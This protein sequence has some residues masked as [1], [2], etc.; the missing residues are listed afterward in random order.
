MVRNRYAWLAI[1][2]GVLF[3]LVVAPTEAR[4]RAPYEQY[5]IAGVHL[6][7]T[8]AQVVRHLGRPIYR[9]RDCEPTVCSNPRY[10]RAAGGWTVRYPDRLEVVYANRALADYCKPG[11]P[12]VDRI[13]TGSP[14]DRF[15][16]G[17]HVG[18]SEAYLKEKFK[19]LVCSSR[20]SEC[21]L[22]RCYCGEPNVLS[23]YGYN[24]VFSLSGH[25]VRRI[26]LQLGYG[27]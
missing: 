18:S 7:E 13:S 11:T 5:S 22:L 9:R 26:E 16:N 25:R 4:R 14:L 15:A 19:H 20:P 3:P 10:C 2:L 17:V 1:V 21:V 24:V 23:G 6:N 12:R 27:S 8:M